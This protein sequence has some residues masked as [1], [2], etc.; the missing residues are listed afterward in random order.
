VLLGREMN[1]SVHAVA[2]S[3]EVVGRHG[4]KCPIDPFDRSVDSAPVTGPLVV[5][6]SH[7]PSVRSQQFDE[8]AAD[9]A[10]CAG[11][12]RRPG[13]PGFG[14]TAHK[15]NVTPAL[16][17]IA[18]PQASWELPE[19]LSLSDGLRST[20]GN[21]DRAVPGGPEPRTSAG[22]GSLRTAKILVGA[23]LFAAVII[24][25]IREW[26][27]VSDTV[28]EIGPTATLGSL[29]FALL[30]LAASA[31]TW[32]R[33]LGELG[34]AVS[35]PAAMKIYLVGQLGKY[36]PGGVWALVIQIELA[37]AA[38]VRRAQAFGAGVVAVGIN[39]LTGSAL[40]LGVLPVLDGGSM[41]RYSAAVAAF[42]CCA[43]MLS[44]P[45]LGLLVDT[46]L[47]LARQ[48]PLN[49]RP[50]WAGILVATA[51]STANW[52]LYG[53]ALAVLAIAAG[54]D[55]SRTLLLALPAVALALTIGL[56]IVVAPSGIGVREAVL[57]AALS[58]VLDPTRGLGVALVLRLVFTIADLVG[59]ALTLPIRLQGAR[60]A[61]A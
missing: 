49:R 24:V 34:A 17:R 3:S 28:A 18:R 51:Y 42:I 60:V 41:L 44:P 58:P 39:I 52:L 30:G 33:S 7:G 38:A 23:S 37:R 9:E 1:Q 56:F 14:P 29:T 45:I 15:S 27:E 59:A 8:V 21:M 20:V 5:E 36:I 31:L 50:G 19:G 26:R 55:P 4:L 32:R 46:G 35:V 2:G 48:E 13:R 6:T 57:V 61:S 22:G 25:T 54:A 47:K 12:E 16:E 43:I 40:G 10:R 53:L 11:Y